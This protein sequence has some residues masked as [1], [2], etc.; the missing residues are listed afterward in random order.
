[1]SRISI[2]VCLTSNKKKIGVWSRWDISDRRV[3][4]SRAMS[5]S[6]AMNVS[7][8]WHVSHLLCCVA[9]MHVISQASPLRDSSDRPVEI[10]HAM[11]VSSAHPER[12]RPIRLSHGHEAR[13]LVHAASH[14]TPMGHG[15]CVARVCKRLEHGAYHALMRPRRRAVH[16]DLPFAVTLFHDSANKTWRS[17]AGDLGQLRP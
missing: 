9:P 13:A 2:Y 16:L 11:P 3:E 8:S 12:L 17:S 1:V 7:A 6:R 10:S 5:V 14:K 15:V 4:I